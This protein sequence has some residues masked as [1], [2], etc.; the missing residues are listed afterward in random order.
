MQN[1][2]AIVTKVDLKI[3]TECHLNVVLI[4]VQGACNPLGKTVDI[5]VVNTVSTRRVMNPMEFVCMV[6]R[7]D[8]MVIHVSK[9]GF[10][11]AN[12]FNCAYMY[13]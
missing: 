5:L 12:Y 4:H 9:V 10:I 7:W 3:I 8:S 2:N 1:Q 6:V 11:R 13:M